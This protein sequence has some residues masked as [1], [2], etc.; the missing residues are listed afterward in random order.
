[1]PIVPGFQQPKKPLSF[2]SL[3]ENLIMIALS[4]FHEKSI[5]DVLFL[6]NILHLENPFTNTTPSRATP[7]PRR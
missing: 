2:F 4:A 3:A 7:R 1:M 6:R 5:D